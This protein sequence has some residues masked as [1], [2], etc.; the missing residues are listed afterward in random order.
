MTAHRGEDDRKAIKQE[1]SM[2]YH[3][4]SSFITPQN[5][6]LRGTL[7]GIRQRQQDSLTKIGQ[8]QEENLAD[9]AARGSGGVR[10]GGGEGDNQSINQSTVVREDANGSI[11]PSTSQLDAVASE[12]HLQA[13]MY[14]YRE[15]VAQTSLFLDT[16]IKDLLQRQIRRWVAFWT[17]SILLGTITYQSALTSWFMCRST[18]GFIDR[19]IDR[20]IDWLIDWLS[21]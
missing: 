12:S 5:R 20:S 11:N 6:D 1:P 19:S 8:F 21:D 18:D 16:A 9:H 2:D 4:S 17:R 3:A 7:H 14:E 15:Y 13:E 10:N